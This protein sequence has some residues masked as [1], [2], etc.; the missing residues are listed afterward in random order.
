M[1]PVSRHSGAFLAVKHIMGDKVDFEMCNLMEGAHKTPEFAA[2]NPYTQIPAFTDTDG[3]GMGETAAIILYAAGKYGPEYLQF[4]KGPN[5]VWALEACAS[6]IYNGG[7]QP[8]PRRLSPLL[9]SPY[10]RAPCPASGWTDV[11]YPCFGFIPEPAD[12]F[13]PHVEKLNKNIAIFAETFLKGKFIGGD[14]LCVADFRLAP[15]VQSMSH[16]F[17]KSKTGFE[18]PERFA[19]YLADFKAACPASA[20]LSSAGGY[21]IEEYLT[22]KEGESKA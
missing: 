11:C 18:M 19:T 22:M 14:S 21:S 10:R 4:D 5:A 13:A 9:L 1:T 8:P 7:A 17:V 16:G 20:M 15:L 6:Y 12:G 3:T 2:I